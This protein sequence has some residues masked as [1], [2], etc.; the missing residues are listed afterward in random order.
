[1]QKMKSMGL[2]VSV[3]ASGWGVEGS[4]STDFQ[5]DS[6]EAFSNAMTNWS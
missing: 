4:V 2:S 1:M 5:K 3:A 6:K